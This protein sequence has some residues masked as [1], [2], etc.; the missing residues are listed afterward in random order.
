MNSSLNVTA[1]Y[2][3]QY[4]VTLGYTVTNGADSSGGPTASIVAFGNSE[5][6][7]VNQTSGGIWADAGT[8][9]SLPNELPGS[10]PGERWIT[11]FTVS[12]TVTSAF[13]ITPSYD[14]QFMLTLDISPTGIPVPLSQ[15][16]GWYDAGSAQDVTL[17]A[18]RGWQFQ[19]WSGQEVGSYSGTVSSLLVTHNSPI[20]ETAN[21]YTALTITTPGT[22]SV[23]YSFTNV[24]GTVGQG[25][26]KMVYVPPGQML[27]VSANPF[28]VFYAFSSWTG[29]ITGGPNAT[30]VT[31]NPLTFSVNSPA[32]LNVANLIGIIIVAVVVLVAIAS[33]ILLRR[34]NGPPEGEEEY[35]EITRA[36]AKL[37]KI[38]KALATTS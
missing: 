35:S 19:S 6:V 11:N 1:T 30:T 13:S 34:R 24:T 12:E 23:A 29:N 22:G 17:I 25:Q 38:W 15:Q 28:P 32:S 27:S 8:T 33:V 31:Q 16:S 10:N 21:F 7:V 37:S 18:G 2:Y 26:S 3:N 9:I 20:T 36:A 5:S 4:L 14:H